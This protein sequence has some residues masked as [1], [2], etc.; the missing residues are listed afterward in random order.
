MRVQPRRGRRPGARPLLRGA[1]DRRHVRARRDARARARRRRARGF[2]GRRQPDGAHPFR[3]RR[4]HT[5]R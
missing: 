1:P 2:D 3:A 4:G 5:A